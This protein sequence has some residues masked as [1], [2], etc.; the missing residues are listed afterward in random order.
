ME[1]NGI[2]IVIERKKIKNMYLRLLPPQGAVHVSA[3]ERMPEEEIRRFIL[4]KY[5]WVVKQQV[6]IRQMPEKKELTYESGEE[7]D[8]WGKKYVLQVV[9]SV[10]NAG[11]S[12]LGDHLILRVK[13]DSPPE[14]RAKV[15]NAWYREEL[16][17]VIP[18]LLHK[19]E[20]VI[21]V[22]SSV[23]TIRDMK[24]RWGTCNIRTCKICFNLQLAKKPKI[25][26][27]YVVVH[28]LVHLLEGSHNKV[29][30]AY[31][32]QFLPN[33]RVIKKELNS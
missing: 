6:R 29:F 13:P 1:V 8:C 11:V 19:W 4:A 18:E 22:K 25:C 23:F 16:T 5:D 26:L 9:P 17:K 28:E 33:W 10:E 32:D 7:V 24:T 21:G 15:L 30:K 27:E 14:A 20:N 31:M 12:L 2:Q 3:P